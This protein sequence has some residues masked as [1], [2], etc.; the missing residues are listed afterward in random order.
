MGVIMKLYLTGGS[1]VTRSGCAGYGRERN[2]LEYAWREGGWDADRDGVMEGV[3]HNT[4]DVEFYGPNPLSGVYYLGA[5]RACEEMARAAGDAPFAAECRRLFDNGSKW[6]DANLFN[7]EYYIQKIQGI[8]KER[9]A[10]GL[11]SGMAPRYRASRFPARD[12]CLGSA[13]GSVLAE[14]AGLGLLPAE[15]IRKTLA[16]I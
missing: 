14:V 10:E 1:P 7:G 5:L 6:L 11:M 3:Q 12:G 15:N 4:Y 8:P 9:I 13:R 2:A 16:S